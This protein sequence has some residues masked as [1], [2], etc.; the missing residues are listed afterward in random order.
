MIKNKFTCYKYFIFVLE[1]RYNRTIESA[2]EFTDLQ[3]TS[4]WVSSL[5]QTAGFVLSGDSS[6]LL[7]TPSSGKV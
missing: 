2:C 5:F 4:S 7:Q 1:A 6:K 3:Q